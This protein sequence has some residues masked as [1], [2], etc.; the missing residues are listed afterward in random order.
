[1]IT[2][3][4]ETSTLLGSVAVLDGDKILSYQESQ[5][6]GSHS[7]IL[8]VLVDNALK[9]SGKNL[10]DIDAFISGTG[11]GSFTGI[12]ISLNA[13]KSYAYCFNKPVYGGNSLQ[14]LAYATKHVDMAQQFKNLPV[15][16]MINA[17]KNMVYVATH[18]FENGCLRVVKSPEVIRVQNLA[19][20]VSENSVV[21]GDGFSTYQK[22]FPQE[23]SEKLVRVEGVLDDP[24]AKTL[25]LMANRNYLKSQNWNEL[26]PLYLR[27]S[28]AEE[29]LQGIKYQPL[30]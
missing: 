18:K 25:G 15:I 28:E 19:D 21:C 11:P 9:E 1:M 14:S 10:T 24:Q 3:S 6:Q 2:L 5:R 7:D 23:L 22:F 8:N 17:Y 26:L 20:Y 4:C 27:A 12:R 29:N 30:I 13:I 16:S